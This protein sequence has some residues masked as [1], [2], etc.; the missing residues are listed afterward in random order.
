MK[1]ILSILLFAAL[2]AVASCSRTDDAR[3]AVAER[4]MAEHPDS[5]LLTLRQIDASSLN[6]HNT[7]LYALLLTQAQ[8]KND[9]TATSDSLINIALDY[10]S[11]GKRHIECLI[12][13][14]AV[15]QELGE[16]QE[17]IDYLKKAEAATSPTDNEML[18][19]INMRLGNIYMNSYI[20]NNEDIAKYKKAL[21]HYKLS[22]NKKYQ[23]ACLGTVGALYRAEN[24]D[25]AYYYINAAIKLAEELG[26]SE[27]IAYHKE[28]LAR[29]YFMD[30]LINKAKD[31]AM[32]VLSYDVDVSDRVDIYV[33]LIGI[34]TTLGKPDSAMLYS[35]QI[36]TTGIHPSQKV[37][38]LMALTKL[39]KDMGN[40]EKAFWVDHRCFSLVDSI[41]K[42]SH[43][44]EL[45]GLELRYDKKEAEVANAKLSNR[46]LVL[47]LIILIMGLLLVLA[48][49]IV[50][51]WKV[52]NAN[53]LMIIS[54]LEN[55]SEII[56]LRSAKQEQ[57]SK[58]QTDEI[59]KLS[60]E[61]EAL[62][63]RLTRKDEA[64]IQMRE[65]INWQFCNV[66]GLLAFA[67]ECDKRPA[68]FMK[69]FLK[70]VQSAKNRMSD[71]FWKT[72]QDYV[73]LCYDNL[74]KKI[75]TDYPKLTEEDLM[76]IAM[77]KC[78]FTYISMTIC[79]GYKDV[80]YVNVK[81]QRIAKK[82]GTDETLAIFISQYINKLKTTQVYNKNT[83]L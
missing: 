44:S 10:F 69:E 22:G 24:M 27:R 56:K 2:L 74:L 52:R 59:S 3:L 76:I 29:A 14:G 41:Q 73:N 75:A 18:G 28:T 58:K 54:Q 5:A 64:E 20:E 83:F 15:L 34:Y 17:A 26:N 71:S 37:A 16:E 80:N 7:A 39:Y 62:R 68:K 9:I 11:D 72:M 79:M 30:S 47:S 50:K 65:I 70:T 57:K 21:H 81:K 48:F 8:Y 38:M 35:E 45:Y 25:S 67:H 33:D 1:H 66:N 82:I 32:D 4:Q 78:G 53:C 6:R 43:Q 12:Y 49:A 40:F 55:E 77:Q 51:R 60:K 13:K 63:N 46:Q 19:Y 31:V 42:S 36:D 61:S 23:L